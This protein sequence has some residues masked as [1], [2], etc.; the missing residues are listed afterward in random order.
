MVCE[1]LFKVP[2]PEVIDHAAVVAPPPKDAPESVIA[3]G[4]VDWQ[5]TFGPPGFTVDA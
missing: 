3:V 1:L 4:A 2:P 5:I